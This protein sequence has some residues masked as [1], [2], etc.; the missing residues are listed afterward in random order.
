LS[1][2]KKKKI[3]VLVATDLAARGIDIDKLPVVVNYDL[4]RSAEGYIHR[5]GR[6]ARAGET[7]MA[8]TF[9]G[10][11]DNAH[12]ALL[13]KR[14]RMRLKRETVKDFERTGEAGAGLKGQPPVKGK[15][16]SKKDK[17]R[18]AAAKKEG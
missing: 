8:V 15:R 7:G 13:E 18:A 16:M 3:R 2:F 17:A 6:T 9:V 10:H 4:P 5:I 11:E 14:L 12:M 1:D